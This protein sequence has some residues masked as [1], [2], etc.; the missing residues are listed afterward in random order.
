MHAYIVIIP[1]DCPRGSMIITVH[2]YLCIV[3]WP[4]HSP[5]TISWADYRPNPQ[6]SVTLEINDVLRFHFIKAQYYV[7]IKR[8]S[9]DFKLVLLGISLFIQQTVQSG[10][11]ITYYTCILEYLVASKS[12]DRISTITF[13]SQDNYFTH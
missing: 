2:C 8:M 13:D 11:C 12:I 1:T 3:R 9:I 6:K 10:N 7:D 4:V 5:V